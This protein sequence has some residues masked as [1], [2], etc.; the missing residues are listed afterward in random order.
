[1][2]PTENAA[3]VAAAA[4]PPKRQGWD[5]AKIVIWV[6]LFFWLLSFGL[7]AITADSIGGSG[8]D[9][10]IFTAIGAAVFFFVPVCGWSVFANV[11]MGFA[12]VML[13][14]A[15]KGRMRGLSLAF[16]AFASMPL[17]IVYPPPFPLC[18]LHITKLHAG[19]Y[20]WHYSL[21][22]SAIVVASMAWRE[23]L[24]QDMVQLLKKRNHGPT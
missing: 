2:G 16:L 13:K 3:Q 6:C 24:M 18:P 12:P 19:F 1:M 23:R 11:F 9:I 22:A 21:L 5:F 7:P 8:T 10:G 20:I 14:H 15:R 17:L 4:I